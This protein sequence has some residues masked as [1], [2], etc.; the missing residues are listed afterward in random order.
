VSGGQCSVG[1]V[2]TVNSQDVIYSFTPTTTGDYVVQ[3]VLSQ[4]L[5]SPSILYITTD[6]AA[7]STAACVF[8]S[9]DI[10]SIDNYREAVHLEAATTYYLVLDGIFEGDPPTEYTF[11]LNANFCGDGVVADD[12]QCDDGE[13]A[14]GDGCDASCN[15]ELYSRCDEAYPSNCAPI[16][17]LYAPANV[18]DPTLRAEI[19]MITGGG[20]AYWDPATTP[21]LTDLTPYDCVVTYGWELFADGPGFGEILA[22]Y[23]DSVGTAVM[24][25]ALQ[26][27][28]SYF[29]ETTLVGPAYSPVVYPTLSLSNTPANY[30]LDGTGIL[31]DN[32]MSLTSTNWDM[33]V[34]TQGDGVAVGTLAGGEIMAAYRSDFRVVYNNGMIQS[35]QGDWARLVANSCAAAWVQ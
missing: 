12:E 6:C 31:F 17:I 32:V 8:G 18:D 1:G 20:V 25:I 4:P 15:V 11:R 29:V 10:Y 14:P 9:G 22:S 24:G 13:T 19:A 5:A 2:S 26:F 27:S 21:I 35:G 3:R 34:T 23:V 16:N 7:L 28:A 30:Q 33:S